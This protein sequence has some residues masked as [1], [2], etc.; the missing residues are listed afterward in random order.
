[1]HAVVMVVTHPALTMLLLEVS[2]DARARRSCPL[3]THLFRV[4]TE[5]RIRWNRHT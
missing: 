3:L 2:D 5:S 4:M 1:M